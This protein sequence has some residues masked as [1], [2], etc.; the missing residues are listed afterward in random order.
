MS[1][2]IKKIGVLTSGGDA[3]GMNAAI[4]SVVRTAVNEGIEVSGIMRG[5]EGLISGELIPMESRSVSNILSHGGTILKTARSKEFITQEGQGKAVK[6]LKDND[7]D[8]LVIIGGNGS[9]QGAICLERDWGVK[10]IGVP[11]TIDNDLGDTDYTIGAHTSVDTVLDAVDKIRDT[12]SSMERIY[13]IEVMGR[14]EPYIAI[15]A[16]LAG[17]AEEILFPGSEVDIEQISK[18]IQEADKKGKRSWIVIL[19]EGYGNAPTVTRQI[20]ERTGYSVRGVTLGH[21]QRGGSPNAPDR[22]L[23]SVMGAHAIESLL[24]GHHGK[25]VGIKG[26]TLHLVPYQT[27]CFERDKDRKLHSML[28][29]LTKLLAK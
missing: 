18:E 25:M 19:S 4:R 6:V 23:A 13:V 8:A 24:G 16:G 3:P 1:K 10:T 5:Y 12:V 21:I 14:E 17:G 28:Y 2:Q 7:I 27:A 20:A 22:V 11:G 15:M 26:S 9:L 29:D